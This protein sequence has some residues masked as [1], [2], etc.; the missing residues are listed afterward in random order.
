MA[1]GK[2]PSFIRFGNSEKSFTFNPDRAVEVHRKIAELKS[3]RNDQHVHDRI[4]RTSSDIIPSEDTAS[5]YIDTSLT[6]SDTFGSVNRN[7]FRT[8]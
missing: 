5:N 6:R 8:S 7:V 1:I 3:R 2:N 4:V